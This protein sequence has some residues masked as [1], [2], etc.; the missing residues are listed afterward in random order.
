MNFVLQTNSKVLRIGIYLA[1]TPV[2]VA[3]LAA[4]PRVARCGQSK[5][6]V[7]PA[8]DV[9]CTSSVFLSASGTP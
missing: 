7:L 6:P 8:Y 5:T 2:G 3:F 4:V 9:L 1:L